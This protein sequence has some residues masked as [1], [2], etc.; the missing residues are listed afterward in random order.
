MYCLQFCFVL[1][2]YQ[3]IPGRNL[4]CHCR[5]DKVWLVYFRVWGLRLP[6]FV[7]WFGEGS[8]TC[9]EECYSHQLQGWLLLTGVCI[10]VWWLG[11]LWCGKMFVCLGLYWYKDGL[12][13]LFGNWRWKFWSDW[14]DAICTVLNF[15]DVVTYVCGQWEG[16]W[17][18]LMFWWDRLLQLQWDSLSLLGNLLECLWLLDL[19]DLALLSWAK[20]YLSWGF[21][22]VQGLLHSDVKLPVLWQL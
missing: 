21:L 10:H 8:C 9:W 18:E 14:P 19:W 15:C 4:M 11:V 16:L 6:V 3:N 5:G 7:K 2:I 12:L 17:L 22:L 20:L 13:M 1:E